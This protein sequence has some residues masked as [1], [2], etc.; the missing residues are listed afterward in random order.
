L[1][2]G[3]EIPGKDFSL[4]KASRRQVSSIKK[5]I[6]FAIELCKY[7]ATPGG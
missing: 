1:E 2:V 3:A 6:G 5:R 4:L 7:V